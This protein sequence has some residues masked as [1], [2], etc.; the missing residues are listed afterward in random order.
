MT[1]TLDVLYGE[2]PVHDSLD[3]RQADPP[4]LDPPTLDPPTLAD[5]G[6]VSLTATSRVY[7]DR[8]PARRTQGP[9]RIPS[10]APS[11]G[12]ARL[13]WTPRVRDPVASTMPEEEVVPA[14]L[15]AGV[16]LMALAMG[17]LAAL[18]VAVVGHVVG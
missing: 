16:A 18:A 10:E 7:Q 12:G 3:S 14:A 2:P 8:D 6:I 4:A 5:L 11:T 17:S 1:P 15:R 9:R 13:M